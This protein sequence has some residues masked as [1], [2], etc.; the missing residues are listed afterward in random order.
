MGKNQV[1]NW[2]NVPEIKIQIY[3]HQGQSLA[4]TPENL[5]RADWSDIPRKRIWVRKLQ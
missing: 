4:N 3:A 1:Y 5:I 2:A